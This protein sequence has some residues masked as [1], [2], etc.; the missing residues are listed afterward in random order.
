MIVYLD[1]EYRCHVD[2]DGTRI[3][4]E[5]EF[6]DGKCKTFI[7][8]YR[9]IPEGHT[10]IRPDGEE[11]TGDV[12]FPAENYEALYMAQ[13]QYELDLASMNDMK[14]ALDILGVSE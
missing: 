2:D 13:Q 6:F 10:W 3:P 7:E 8:G 12:M 14:N 4:I 5:D 1:S 11:F 9:Y